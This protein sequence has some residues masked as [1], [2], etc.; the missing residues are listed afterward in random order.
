MSL[1]AALTEVA[2]M[3]P[4]L[5]QHLLYTLRD[6]FILLQ[7][8]RDRDELRLRFGLQLPMAR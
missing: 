3:Q 8:V 2:A 6:W 5:S 7:R 1:H 4:R